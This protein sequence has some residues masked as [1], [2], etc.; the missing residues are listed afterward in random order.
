M[1]IETQKLI[2][3]NLRLLRASCGVSQVRMA[4]DVGLTRLLYAAY[5]SGNTAP[6]TEILYKLAIRNGIKMEYFFIENSEDFLACIS[7]SHYY[8][9]TLANLAYTFEKLSNFAKGMLIEKANQLLEQDKQ[10]RANREALEKR[11]PKKPGSK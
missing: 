7:G 9:D 10:I 11:K 4:V 3:R 5:E 6:D 1:K 8:D 2:A